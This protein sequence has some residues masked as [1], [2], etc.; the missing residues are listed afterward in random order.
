MHIYFGHT[1]VHLL[2]FIQCWDK[3]CVVSFHG[4]DVM[5]KADSPDYA[6]K[7]NKVFDAVPL[8][9]ARSRSL[10]QRLITLGCRRRKRFGSIGLGFRCSNFPM[11]AARRPMKGRWR[12]L[13]ACRLI[14]K[15][16]L[17]TCL[18]AFAL[19][20][21]ENPNAELLIAGKGPLQPALEA[22][23]EQ[24]GMGSEG[25][26]HRVSFAV[27]SAG[28]LSSVPCFLAPERDA[29]GRKSGRNSK[30]HSRSDG[31]RHAGARDAARRN[32]RGGRETDVAARWWTSAI[33]RRWPPR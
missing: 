28:A 16:G 32:P 13:Q 6:A 33:S 20:H 18:R 11:R 9:L 24:L 31:D 8:V 15:K 14:P 26:F 23:A 29:R 25:S 7:L 12:F 5:L 2:P 10:E 3:P 27:G 4:A 19:F 30:L 1:G 17:T 21:Q 22:L